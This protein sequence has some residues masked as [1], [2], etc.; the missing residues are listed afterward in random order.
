[1]LGVLSRTDASRHRRGKA[2]QGVAVRGTG[3]AAWLAVSSLEAVLWTHR[4]A[5][6]AKQDAR[7]LVLQ[8]KPFV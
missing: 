5:Y 4:G 7:A 3:V 1:M 6:E 8:L 2:W